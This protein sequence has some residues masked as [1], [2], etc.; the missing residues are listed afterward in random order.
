MAEAMAVGR[1]ARECKTLEAAPEP[2]KPSR[3]GKKT[4]WR[5][6]WKCQTAAQAATAWP[7]ANQTAQ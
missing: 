1:K 3:S 2:E 6:R 4:Q 5:Q 7:Q